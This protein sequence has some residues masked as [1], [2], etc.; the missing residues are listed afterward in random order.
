M[1][2]KIWCFQWIRKNLEG[3]SNFRGKRD[4]PNCARS[5]ARGWSH[6]DYAVLLSCT[7]CACLTVQMYSWVHVKYWPPWILEWWNCPG[8]I[9]RHHINR[10]VGFNSFWDRLLWYSLLHPARQYKPPLW[11]FTGSLICPDAPLESTASSSGLALKFYM[12]Q[13]LE[14]SLNIMIIIIG[15]NT[16]TSPFLPQDW[17]P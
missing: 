6:P 3:G 7:G 2:N 11:N 10:V 13:Q 8:L 5:G 1:T 12:K 9:V 17:W 4:F 15:T 14:N 16:V